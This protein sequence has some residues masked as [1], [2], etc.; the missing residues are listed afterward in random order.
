M[1]IGYPLDAR[2][3]IID[4]QLPSEKRHYPISPQR[5]NMRVK[6]PYNNQEIKFCTV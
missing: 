2:R 3:I 6:T 1:G 4:L 5:M